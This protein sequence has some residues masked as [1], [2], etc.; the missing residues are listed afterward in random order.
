MT[1]LSSD[2]PWRAT[3]IGVERVL[4][5]TIGGATQVFGLGP[6]HA[7]VEPRL[8]LERVL[9]A[10]GDRMHHAATCRQVHGSTVHRV[11]DLAGRVIEVGRGDA[12]VT[13]KPGVGLAIWT[14]DC[15]PVLL[16][17]DGVVAAVHAG[18]R[19][20]AADVIGAAIREIELAHGRTARDLSVAFGPSVCGA[21]YQVGDE[22]CQALRA[23]VADQARWRR[24]DRVDLR[25]FLRSR[26]ESLGV[27]A[28][29]IETVGGCTVESHQLASYRRDGAAAGRQW[30]LVVL[31]AG[32]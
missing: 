8:R 18:W 9:A 13:T 6:S 30:S 14:A 32:C 28:D 10:F 15:V 17:S 16:T 7:S 3:E 31:D 21:C 5:R 24:G 2:G 26:C 19:G 23:L 11:D 27:S 25:A 20:C 29:R 1:K 12:L 22:V 4:T